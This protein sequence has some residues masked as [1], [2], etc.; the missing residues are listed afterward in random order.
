MMKYEVIESK[1][2]D[3]L[4]EQVNK[5]IQDGWAPLGGTAVGASSDQWYHYQAMTR[6]SE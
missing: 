3:E 6:E 2:L 5:Y 1:F 4:V